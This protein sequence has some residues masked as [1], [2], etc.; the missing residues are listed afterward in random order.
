MGPNCHSLSSLL[1]QTASSLPSLGPPPHGVPPPTAPPPAAPL[2]LRRFH[3]G[4]A[5][6]ADSLSSGGPLRVASRAFAQDPRRRPRLVSSSPG[7]GTTPSPELRVRD[8]P[9][10]PRPPTK[11]PKNRDRPI[12]SHLIPSTKCH[13]RRYLTYVHNRRKVLT[14]LVFW[15]KI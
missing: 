5:S 11:R 12:P 14:R 2:M 10:L 8:V 4:A 1:P 6:R 3:S 13:L 7:G 9:V 15:D